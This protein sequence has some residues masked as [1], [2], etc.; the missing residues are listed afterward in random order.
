MEQTPMTVGN[1]RAALSGLPDDLPII[2]S[3]DEEGNS[4]NHLW[5]AV[6]SKCTVGRLNIEAVY[7]DDVRDYDP[8]DLTDAVVLWP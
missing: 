5:E 7:P 1:L 8:E 4:L 3:S 2:M 6:V